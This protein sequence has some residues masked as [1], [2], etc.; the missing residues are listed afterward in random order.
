MAYADGGFH[1][2]AALC[3]LLGAVCI[4]V[5]TNYANDYLDYVR[6]AD[7][8][9]RKG[10]TRATQAGLVAPRAM[11]W[12]TVLAF[13]GAVVVGL[14]LIV[15]GGWPILAVGVLS[16]ASGVLYT[17][18]RYALAY[19]GLADLFVLIFFGPV[20]VGGTYYVQALTLPSYVVV[21]GLGPGLVSVAILI[22]NNLRDVSEDE[23]A[24]KKTLIVRFGRRFGEA[25]YG[26]CVLA[27]LFLPLVL[28]G[29]TGDH[30][31][32]LATL[33]LIPLALRAWRRLRATDEVWALNP[34]LGVTGRLLMLY[35][36]V[37][38]L[39]WVLT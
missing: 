12:A 31:G 17:Y 1:A 35:G 13:A 3:A 32:A 34:L 33:A 37:F 30:I 14:Y 9:A 20:A 8:E 6:G 11:Q 4:Q 22:V 19:T 23:A 24:E 5:G 21:A 29:M 7:T 36:L 25:A 39:G 18:G 10:P 38:S 26:V 16:I 15:R 28:F 27:P 2:L